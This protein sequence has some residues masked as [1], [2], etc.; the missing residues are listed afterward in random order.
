[1]NVL[2]IRSILNEQSL[3]LL[4]HRSS[5]CIKFL[6]LLIP[7]AFAIVVSLSPQQN[8][9]LHEMSVFCCQ[10]WNISAVNYLFNFLLNRNTLLPQRSTPLPYDINFE[11]SQARKYMFSDNTR[12]VLTMSCVPF[13][14]Y[15]MAFP[16]LVSLLTRSPVFLVHCFPR[17]VFI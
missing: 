2:D 8:V 4:L 6:I 12:T 15:D 16:N 5:K 13:D 3:G 1:M 11:Q 14:P 10:I 9:S 7:R 17:V